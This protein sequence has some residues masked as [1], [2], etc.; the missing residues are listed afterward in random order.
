MP[1]RRHEVYV[2]CLPFRLSEKRRPWIVL[3]D[4]C[5]D[6][7]NPSRMIVRVTPCSTA[8]DL[9]DHRDFLFDPRHPDFPATGLKYEC[10]ASSRAYHVDAGVLRNKKGEIKGDLLTDF[11]E[12]EDS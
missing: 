12:W 10:Y 6:P 5:Q 4:P 2:E 9:R 1:P 3:E 8:E 11:I 7:R